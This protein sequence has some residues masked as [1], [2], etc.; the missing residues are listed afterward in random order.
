M[1]EQEQR[2][3]TFSDVVINWDGTYLYKGRPVSFE[4][5]SYDGLGEHLEK[6]DKEM[7]A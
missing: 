1:D 2:K 5:V 7:M 4:G 3:P 6:I